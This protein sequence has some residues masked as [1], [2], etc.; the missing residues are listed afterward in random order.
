[1]KQTHKLASTLLL[2]FLLHPLTAQEKGDWRASSKTAKSTT[3]DIAFTDQKLYINFSAFTV[4]QIRT[5]TPAEITAA[6]AL[7]APPTGTGNLYRTSIPAGKKFVHSHTLCGGEDTEWVVT[8]LTG[9]TLQLLFFS[10]QDL[11]IL[12]PDAISTSTT[13]CGVYGYSR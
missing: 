10:G 2:L 12:T 5:L 8:Y 1:M 4:A 3:G 6:F 13:L 7:D 11:P 9:H